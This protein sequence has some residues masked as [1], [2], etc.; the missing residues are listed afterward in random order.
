MRW[1][2]LIITSLSAA[3][4]GAGGDLALAYWRQGRSNPLSAPPALVAGI[5][6][7]PLISVTLAGIFVYRHTA[8]RRKL[9]AT[10]TVLL[11]LI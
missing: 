1:K 8:R 6:L 3:L 11:S 7:I 5:V 10:L 4:V 2:L 9:Q